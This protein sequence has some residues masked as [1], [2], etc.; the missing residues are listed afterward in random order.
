M[1]ACSRSVQIRTN[2]FIEGT[3]DRI[4]LLTSKICE[5]FAAKLELL[6]CAIILDAFISAMLFRNIGIG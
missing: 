2:R 5:E 3:R 1:D 6:R 4:V